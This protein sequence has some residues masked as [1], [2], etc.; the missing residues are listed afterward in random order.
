M[1]IISHRGYWKTPEE[2]NLKTAF[3]RSFSLGFGTE[4]DFRDLG[5]QLVI[6]HDPPAS[7]A[8]PADD[9]FACVASYDQTLY[10]A[11]NIKAD[12]LQNLVVDALTRHRLTN[13]FVFD[14]SVP[15]A[16]QWLQTEIP[17]Y[18]RHSDVETEPAIYGQA[19]GVWLDAFQEDWWDLNV[20]SRHLEKNKKVA[21]VSPELHGRAHTEV[22]AMLRSSSLGRSDDIILCTDYPEEAREFFGS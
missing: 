15:D 4:T 21:V 10:V 9:F 11:I 22:W 12:G 16:V 3:D 13:C 2:K 20:I 18:T 5:G 19:A 6:S 1:Q 17:V 8:M 7:S 14:M